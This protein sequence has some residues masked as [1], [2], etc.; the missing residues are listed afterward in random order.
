MFRIHL[1]FLDGIRN[2]IWSS[3][4]PGN[5]VAEAHLMGKE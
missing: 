5:D 1:Q 3:P 4:L 2:V